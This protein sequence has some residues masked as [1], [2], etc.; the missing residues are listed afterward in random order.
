M[1]LYLHIGIEKTGTSSIQSFMDKNRKKLLN[2]YGLLYPKTGLWFDKSHHELAFSVINQDRYD[3]AGIDMDTMFNNLMI[4]ANNSKE[5]KSV[6][7]SSEIFRSIHKRE[8]FD[9]FIKKIKSLFDEIEIILFL[10][11]QSYW[12]LSMYNQ[13][14][15]DPN[16]KY[17]HGFNSF[18]NMFENDLNYLNIIMKWENEFGSKN[19]KIFKYYEKNNNEKRSSIDMVLNYLNIEKTK[20][21]TPEIGLQNISFNR[22][23]FELYKHFNRFNIEPEL[24]EK[25]NRIIHEK[26]GNEKIDYLIGEYSII[27]LREK[28]CIYEKFKKSNEEI[29]LKWFN[30]KGNLFPPILEEKDNININGRI[31]HAITNI[32]NSIIKAKND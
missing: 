18:Y 25:L 21:D 29:N 19:I 23:E 8:E 1:K 4:E 20:L 7:I 24:R 28:K 16:I 5:C 30:S 26:Y 3:S 10:R 14:V 9:I 22:I 31:N 13:Y 2:N 6:L 17:Y 32:L 11:D 15:K 27:S 12:I